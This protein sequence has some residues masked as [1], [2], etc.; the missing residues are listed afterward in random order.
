MLVGLLKQN[1]GEVQEPACG[2]GIAWQNSP[3]QR[4][5]F[6]LTPFPTHI[7]GLHV[8]LPYSRKQAG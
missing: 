1:E 3:A 4:P 5:H 6:S 8:V 2:G 7:I